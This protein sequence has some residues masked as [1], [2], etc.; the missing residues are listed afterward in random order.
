MSPTESEPPHLQALREG[1][2]QS[3]SYG[4]EDVPLEES[5]VVYVNYVNVT[6]SLP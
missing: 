2:V 5:A 3:G 4:N 6:P 1:S